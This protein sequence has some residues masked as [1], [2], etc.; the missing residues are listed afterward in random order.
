MNEQNEQDYSY[1]E[2]NTT[3]I[4]GSK[5]ITK[6]FDTQ[7]GKISYN[8]LF[9]SYNYGSPEQPI[10]NS[11]YMEGPVVSSYGIVT[12]E[13]PAN[14]PNGPYTKVSHSIMTT[15]DL[16]NAEC[17]ACLSK[18]EKIH[19]AASYILAKYGSEI[20]YSDNEYD[21]SK[22]GKIFKNPVFY[23][24]EGGKIIEGRNPTMWSKLNHYRT[25]KTLFTD[26]NGTHIEW[27]F[28]KDVDLKFV[29]L[30]HFEKIY[31]GTKTSIQIKLISGVVISI[32]PINSKSKQTGSS[33]IQRL[34]DKY[35]GLSSQVESQ[36]AQIRM[37]RQDLIVDN[38]NT[39]PT[40]SIHHIPTGDENSLKDFLG[41]AP[42]NVEPSTQQ[43][44][45]NVQQ[46]P[47]LNVQQ[48]QL[49]TLNIQQKN[50]ENKQDLNVLPQI[51]QTEFIQIK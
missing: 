48:P 11:F 39:F 45:L 46:H 9:L 32:V 7:N 33:T 2:T 21:P 27:D 20:G 26:L 18:I 50:I 44:Q 37:D 4:E 35:K 10:R 51:P 23:K 5:P 14:G 6:S 17:K 25:N 15:F 31:I 36:I 28:L 3:H 47:Q 40:G 30:W 12:K 22:P 19:S 1:I 13:E 16:Q 49:T 42:L 41:G 29:P 43:P 8:E 34:K 24:R 38:N